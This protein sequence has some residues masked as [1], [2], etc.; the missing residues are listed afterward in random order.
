MTPE[1]KVVNVRYDKFRQINR[2]LEFIEDVLPNLPKE[3]E[4]TVIDL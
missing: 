1:G 3:R 2:F 4:I